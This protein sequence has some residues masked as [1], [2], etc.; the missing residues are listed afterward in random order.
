M[1]HFGKKKKKNDAPS[2]VTHT[3]HYPRPHPA[4]PCPTG[5]LCW[6]SFSPWAFWARW[7]VAGV[8]VTHG[9]GGESLADEVDGKNSNKTLAA[10]AAWPPAP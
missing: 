1:V 5:L 7:C 10:C 6:P 3:Q 8:G 2:G 4:Q 9:E